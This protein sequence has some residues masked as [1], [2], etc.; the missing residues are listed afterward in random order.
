MVLACLAARSQMPDPA[1]DPLEKAYNAFRDKH[2]EAAIA[3]FR[4]AVEAAPNRASIRKDLAYAYLKTGETEAARGQFAEAVR[5]APD[6]LHAALE[7]AFLCHE[8]G[9]TATARAVFDGIRKSSD[10]AVRETAEQAFQNIDK[11]LVEGI[12]RW[13]EALQRSPSDFSAHQE[14]A[15]LAEKRQDN[16]L[17]A[18][19]YWQAWSLRPEL[20]DLLV[21]LGL[22]WKALGEEDKAHAAFLAASRS[23][24]TRTAESAR[25]LLP[26]RYPYVYEF[27]NAI[28]LDPRNFDL[29][30]ELAYLLLAMERREEA[31][32]VFETVVRLAPRDLLSAA[33]L[34]FLRLARNDRD[35]ALPLLEMVLHGDNKELAERVRSVLQQGSARPERQPRPTSD[36]KRMGDRSYQA[37]YLRD[38]LKFYNAAHEDD[39]LDFSVILKLGWTHNVLRQDDQAARWFQMARRSPDTAIAR[40]AARA[41]ENLSPALARFRT[42]VWFFPSYSSRWR[43]VFTYGQAKVEMKLGRLPLRVY[44]SL[45]F[46]GDTRHVTSE[47]RPQY[48]SESSFILGGGLATDPWRGVVLWGEAGSAVGYRRRT[49]FPRAGPDYRGGVSFNRGFGRLLGAPS[50]GAFFETSEDGV[51][52]SRFQNDFIIYTQNRLGFTARA[53]EALGGLQAQLYW[54]ANAST[55]ARRQYWANTVETGPGIRFRWK[56]MPPSWVFSVNVLR[57]AYT[58]N[59]GNPRRPNFNDVRVGMWCAVTK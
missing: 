44:P 48:L 32:E 22:A 16:A 39:P 9:R 58:R 40:E 42:T 4:K 49:D 10:A 12:A 26:D 15:Q 24:D 54:N 1:Q 33:Q 18:Q 36:S 28:D 35:G 53:I 30:R 14:L 17:A 5:L 2:F 31:E 47:A 19:H 11:P 43:D 27:R 6:D 46:I 13:T 7:Y 41:H 59:E 38:A 50:R 8:T 25:E 45:R 23:K 55:D 34:G 21:K 37:G 20:R 57:G 52:I 56:A 51:F 3:H 29:R